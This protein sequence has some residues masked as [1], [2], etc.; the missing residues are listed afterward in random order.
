VKRP[1][2]PAPEKQVKWI[3]TNEDWY[4]TLEGNYT[5]PNPDYC[6]PLPGP[7]VRVFMTQLTTK[8]WRVAVWGG[9]DFGLEIDLPEDNRYE[10]QHLFDNI[11]NFTRQVQ[12]KKWGF[13]HA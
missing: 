9:D 3:L 2:P 12:L 7:A 13:H 6:N 8:E 11:I 4:P 5:C 1:K 10:A